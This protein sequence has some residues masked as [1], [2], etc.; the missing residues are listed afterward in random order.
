MKD[1]GVKVCVTGNGADELFAGYY[2]H[3]NLY[4]NSIKNKIFKTTFKKEW[5]KNILPLIR[6]KEYKSLKR[7]NLKSYFSLIDEKYLNFKKIEMYKEK[8]F[9]KNLLRNKLI[10]ELL[11]QTIP[12]ALTEDDLNSMY[13]SIEN[14]SPFLNRDLV[15]TSFKFPTKYLMKNSFNKYLLRE[16]SKN[17]IP[18]KIRLNR[19]EERFQCLF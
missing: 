7:K 4:Y 10:N 6:N 5:E 14:R 19:R 16:S 2:H 15:E 13:Y 8:Y 1:D 9:L 12:L 3:Y 18:E 11:Y 17:I